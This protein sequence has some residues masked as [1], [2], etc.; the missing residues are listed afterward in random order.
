MAS[1]GLLSSSSK[2]DLPG[3][4]ESGCSCLQAQRWSI[5]VG[6]RMPWNI[7]QLGVAHELGSDRRFGLHWAPVSH[8][9]KKEQRGVTSM[10]TPHCLVLRA[11]TCAGA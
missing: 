6:R 5:W 4:V 11:L 8:E 1:A 3:P 7:L 2:E 10:Q 9:P